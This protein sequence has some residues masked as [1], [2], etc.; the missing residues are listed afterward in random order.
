M[1]QRYKMLM[2][3]ERYEGSLIVTVQDTVLITVHGNMYW[4]SIVVLVGLAETIRAHNDLINTACSIKL[5]K[6][7]LVKIHIILYLILF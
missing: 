3:L 6:D 5:K 7:L 2:P 1:S 4:C